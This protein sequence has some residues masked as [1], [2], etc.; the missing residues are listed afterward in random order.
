[1]GNNCDFYL[2]DIKGKSCQIF[3]EPTKYT[4]KYIFR[5]ILHDS[6]VLVPLVI[7][8]D[9]ISLLFTL[10]SNS[11][12]RHSGQVSFPGGIIEEGDKSF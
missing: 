1:M 9:Q 4:H 7:Q 12:E 11:L 5:R 2:A 10:R 8:N 6:A 3:L